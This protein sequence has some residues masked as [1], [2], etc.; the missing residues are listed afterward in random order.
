M[1]SELDAVV[2]RIV[3]RVRARIQ[4]EQA[5]PL[6]EVRGTWQDESAA[7]MALTS[8]CDRLGL[9]GAEP[10]Q[11][12]PPSDLARLIDHTLL[13]PTSTRKDIERVCAE[14]RKHSF[15]SVCV[16]TTWIGLV[17]RLLDGCST[18]AICV[19]GFPLGAMSIAAK[20]DE[21]RHAIKAGADEIDMVLN[22]GALKSGDY[23][24]ALEDIR[25]VV[26]AS[27]G[28]PVKV[29]IETAMLDRDEKVAASALCKAGGAAFV[30][31]STG[32]GG[33]GATVEDIALIRAVVGP[34]MGIKASGGVKTASDIKALVAA[35]ATRVGASASVAIVTGGAGTGGY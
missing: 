4:E 1:S 15:A 30:K 31:T 7:R 18:M 28:R 32:F 2:D 33:G 26:A 9:S 19:V 22:I 3:E 6:P 8:G 24:T 5:P 34:T 27:Q 20:A 10:L 25:Q 17:A 35:G 14:A 23:D 12:A 11:A 13:K 29:I 16:N 21:T